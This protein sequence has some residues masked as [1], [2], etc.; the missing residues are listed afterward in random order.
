MMTACAALLLAVTD[1][2]STETTAPV[3]GSAP[4]M[5]RMQHVAGVRV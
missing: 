5:G 2:V 4:A 1:Q 3:Q